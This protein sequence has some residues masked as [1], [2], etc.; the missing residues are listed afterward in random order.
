MD[1]GG[2]FTWKNYPS[3]RDG[4]IKTRWFICLGRVNDNPLETNDNLILLLAHT[5]TTQL[6]YYGAG[7]ERHMRPY[8]EYMVYQKWGG[9]RSRTDNPYKQP[10]HGII[11]LPCSAHSRPKSRVF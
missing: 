11:F 7:E 2:V 1:I 9:A 8:M 5:A 10:E 4:I 3:Q 6:H